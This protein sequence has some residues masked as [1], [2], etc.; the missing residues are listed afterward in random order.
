MV[1]VVDVELEEILKFLEALSGL[2]LSASGLSA[3]GAEL[4]FSGRYQRDSKGKRKNKGER[5]MVCCLLFG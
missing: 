3:G 1:V 4:G 5:E 2:A